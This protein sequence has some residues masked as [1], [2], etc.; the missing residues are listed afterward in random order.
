MPTLFTPNQLD[1]GL[2]F[3][4]PTPSADDRQFNPAPGFGSQDSFGQFGQLQPSLEFGLLAHP[5]HVRNLDSAFELGSPTILENAQ[6]YNQ[7]L[8]SE[9]PQ[10]FKFFQLQ[11]DAAGTEKLQSTAQVQALDPRLQAEP[12]QDFQDKEYDP[13]KNPHHHNYILH[14]ESS[15]L[16]EPTL[17]A[18]NAYHYSQTNMS[19]SSSEDQTK[20]GSSSPATFYQQ[21]DIDDN[22]LHGDGEFDICSMLYEG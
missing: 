14:P 19:A 4:S 8:D 10:S 17:A 5:A 22:G 16:I 1:P 9:A 18:Q 11:K 20:S 15:F 2:G 13:T 6:Q 7:R 12:L 21:F 3:R